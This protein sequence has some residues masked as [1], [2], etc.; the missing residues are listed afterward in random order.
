[1]IKAINSFTLS[2]AVII[3]TNERAQNLINAKIKEGHVLAH[4]YY[5]DDRGKFQFDDGEKAKSRQNKSEPVP[6]R[7]FQQNMLHCSY[8]YKPRTIRQN[9]TSIANSTWKRQY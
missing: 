1:M 4:N 5:R 2:L 3:L 7:I 8:D 6:T 9:Q